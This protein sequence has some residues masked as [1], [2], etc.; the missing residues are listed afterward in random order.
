M[1]NGL[2]LMLLALAGCQT[3]ERHPYLTGIVATSIA[4]SAARSLDGRRDGRAHDVTTQPV[5]CT[6]TSCK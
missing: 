4:I 6:S 5:S 1:K 3:I 2:L